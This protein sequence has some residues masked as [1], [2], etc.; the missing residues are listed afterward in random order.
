MYTPN[1]ALGRWVNKQRQR[2][3]QGLLSHDRVSALKRLGIETNSV[4]AQWERQFCALAAFKAKHGHCN[5][6][7][8]YPAS[9]PLGRWLTRQRYSRHQGQLSGERIQ[10]L[11][12]L[13]V[14]WALKRGPAKEGVNR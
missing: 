2:M 10:R 1:P 9:P 8:K 7:A 4:D 13:G 6:P 12:E 5:V 3:R 14:T 11:T